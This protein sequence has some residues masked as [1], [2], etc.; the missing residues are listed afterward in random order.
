M[1]QTKKI[2]AFYS[3]RFFL[4]LRGARL[5]TKKAKLNRMFGNSY[6]TFAIK[7]AFAIHAKGM[8]RT[9]G[10]YTFYELE[11][12]IKFLLH[13]FYWKSLP[14]ISPPAPAP[15]LSRSFCFSPS[16]GFSAKLLLSSSFDAMFSAYNQTCNCLLNRCTYIIGHFHSTPILVSAQ[17]FP[18]RSHWSPFNV[19]FALKAHFSSSTGPLCVA[20]TWILLWPG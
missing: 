9:A 12:P 11:L 16:S 1:S 2:K 10:A 19:Y 6:N 3:L 17:V 14:S 7:I 15:L 5:P 13:I 8:P 18:T 4:R 20:P